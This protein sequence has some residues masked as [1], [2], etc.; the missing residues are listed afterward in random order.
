[1]RP[2]EKRIGAREKVRARGVH[3]VRRV[4]R[5]RPSHSAATGPGDAR[6]QSLPYAAMQ[7]S[8]NAVSRRTGSAA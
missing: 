7:A 1:M 3:R 5:A 6:S 2:A 4:R 8:C